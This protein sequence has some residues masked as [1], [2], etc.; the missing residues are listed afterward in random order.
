MHAL[1]FTNPDEPAKRALFNANEKFK[2]ARKQ[3][4]TKAF[5]NQA[6]RIS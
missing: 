5:K 1:D 2:D 3:Q 4:L 6:F